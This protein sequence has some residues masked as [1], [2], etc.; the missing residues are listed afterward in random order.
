MNNEQALERAGNSA[1]RDKIDQAKQQLPLPQLMRWLVYD[2]KHIGKTALCPFHRDENPS[3]SVFQKNDGAWWHKC[4][5]GCTEGD[6]I[7]F[8]AKARNL[9]KR[10]AI[11]LYLDMSGF[12]CPRP[13]SSHEYPES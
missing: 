3:F 11:T 6:E 7:A 12:P 13:P 9:S 1:P 10:E 5:V 4:F 8:L 2:E